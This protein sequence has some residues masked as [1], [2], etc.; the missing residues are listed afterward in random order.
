MKQIIKSIEQSIE[1]LDSV[2]V[3]NVKANK[4]VVLL[5]S[6]LNQALR[7]AGLIQSEIEK[8]EKVKAVKVRKQATGE[9][10]SG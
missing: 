9:E 3:P 2:E 6:R 1:R 5:R 7:S 4:N 10:G 8:D